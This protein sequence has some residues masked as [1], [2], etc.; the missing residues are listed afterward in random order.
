MSTIELTASTEI[1][2]TFHGPPPVELPAYLV[3][4][5][6]W[7]YLWPV[8]VWFFDHQPIINA[9]LFGN[10]RRIMNETMRLMKPETAGKTLQIAACTA[11]SPRPS[12]S[13]WTTCTSSTSP[14]CSCAPRAAS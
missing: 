9:I 7:A 5:Y 2:Q 4:N 11:S 3:D 10:Y 6:D 12:R 14:R 13:T 8:S 1:A